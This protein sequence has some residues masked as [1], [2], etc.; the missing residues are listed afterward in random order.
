MSPEEG[1]ISRNFFLGSLTQ[2]N[3]EEKRANRSVL[4]YYLLVRGKKN[5]RILTDLVY[6]WAGIFLGGGGMKFLSF[7]YWY[8]MVEAAVYKH[9]HTLIYIYNLQLNISSA[10]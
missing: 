5:P 7:L 1:R 10:F 8:Q 4:N 3:N 2:E 9:T 6:S